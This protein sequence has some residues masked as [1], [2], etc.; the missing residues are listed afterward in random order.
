MAQGFNQLANYLD[1]IIKLSNGTAPKGFKQTAR[2]KKSAEFFLINQVSRAI[3]EAK[4]E[5]KRKQEQDFINMQTL[6]A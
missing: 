3:L 4:L 2:G 5:L 6:G 1:Q